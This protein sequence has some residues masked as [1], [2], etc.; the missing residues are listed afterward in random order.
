MAE[1]VLE[2]T[3]TLPGGFFNNGSCF[4]EV[5]LRALTGRVEELLAEAS[6]SEILASAITTLLVNCIEQIGPITDITPEIPRNLLV[7]DRDYLLMKLRQ[8]TIGNRVEA[9]LVCPNPQCAKKIDM[10]FDLSHIPIKKGRISSRVFTLKLPNRAKGKKTGTEGQYK[11]DFRLPNGGD[12]EALAPLILKDESEAVNKLLM[13]CI[14]GIDGDNNI[15]EHRIKKLPSSIRRRIEKAMSDLAPQIDLDMEATCPECKRTFPFPFNMSQYFLDEMKAKLDQL[16][17]EVHSLAFYY[18]WPE[19]EILS[20][21]TRKRRKYLE[22]LAEQ[23]EI[24]KK[25]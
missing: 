2:R 18:K 22:L 1:N 20:M 14:Q 24:N 3:F 5:K 19:S 17:R 23:I 13:R 25:E 11:V 12:Q 7:G 16:Y 15:D 9:T 6:D 8:I 4:H 21:T 10:D